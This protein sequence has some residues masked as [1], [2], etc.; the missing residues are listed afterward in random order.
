MKNYAM[1]YGKK[2]GKR[3]AAIGRRIDAVVDPI[4]SSAE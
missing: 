2:D 3:K 1:P 4:V